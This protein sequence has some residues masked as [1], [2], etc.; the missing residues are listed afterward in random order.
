MKEWSSKV[1]TTSSVLIVLQVG[2]AGFP[3]QAYFLHLATNRTATQTKD[4]PKCFHLRPFSGIQRLEG[5]HG[6]ACHAFN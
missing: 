5:D 2:L 1:S 4:S 6:A 3:W